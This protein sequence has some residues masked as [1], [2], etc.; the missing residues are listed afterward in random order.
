MSVISKSSSL[1]LHTQRN[2]VD[3]GSRTNRSSTTSIVIAIS[4]PNATKYVR[5]SAMNVH[6]RKTHRRPWLGSVTRGIRQVEFTVWCIITA[7]SL[8]WPLELFQH[9]EMEEQQV[10]LTINS[11]NE[12]SVIVQTASANVISSAQ[13][14]GNVIL[15][16]YLYRF[17]HGVISLY[18]FYIQLFLL[19]IL[20][21]HTVFWKRDTWLLTLVVFSGQFNSFFTLPINLCICISIFIMDVVNWNVYANRQRR[22]LLNSNKIF[23]KE[24]NVPTC[25]VPKLLNQLLFFY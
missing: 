3:T 17:F 21:R 14:N 2:R 16:C 5:W 12:T 19:L 6:A 13:E 18:C 22:T 8:K 4:L 10:I 1:E 7:E 9:A 25:V 11:N 23:I 20:D 24:F 15:D